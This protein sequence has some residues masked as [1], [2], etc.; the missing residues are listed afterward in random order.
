MSLKE[1][2]MKERRRIQ[3]S[4]SRLRRMGYIET[5]MFTMP[6]IPKRITEGS[7]RRLQKIDID[8]I[9]DYFDYLDY[10]TGELEPAKNERQRRRSRKGAKRKPKQKKYMSLDEI[11]SGNLLSSYGYN[12]DFIAEILQKIEEI[13]SYNFKRVDMEQ[14]VLDFVS[15]FDKAVTVII[16]SVYLNADGLDRIVENTGAIIDL[17]DKAIYMFYRGQGDNIMSEMFELITGEH[18]EVEGEDYSDI[19]EDYYD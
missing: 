18:Q 9:Y 11:V 5:G 10:E 14:E 8:K 17:L 2:Y 6:S 4:F 12:D 13:K 7:I 3:S 19:Y 15:E 1:T 16:Q